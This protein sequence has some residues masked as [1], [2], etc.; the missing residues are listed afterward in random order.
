MST[1]TAKKYQSLTRPEG[2]IAYEVIGDGPL[3]VCVPGMGEL[4]SS[5]RFVQNELVAAGFR[6]ALTDLRGHGDSD[7]TFDTYG[8]VPTAG[9]VAALITELGGP[10][11]IVGN[12]MA[13]GSAVLVAAEHP[14]LVSGLALIGAYVRE[15]GTSTV[16]R[17]LF[18][19]M[20]AKPWAAASWNAYLPKLYAGTKPTDFADYR[21]AMTAAIKRPGHAKAFDPDFPAPTEEARWTADQLH[22]EVMMVPDAGHYPQ[23]QRPELVGPALTAFAR[24]LRHDA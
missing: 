12:S 24:T 20:M 15:Q 21:K 5:Y 1:T 9:D 11:L 3:I 22:A 4:R 2:S 16:A 13:G 10:A 23:A 6:V 17:L 7:T 18:R 19:A 8:D 14:E